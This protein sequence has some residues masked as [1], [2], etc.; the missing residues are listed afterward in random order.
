M[1]KNLYILATFILS[2]SVSSCYHEVDLDGYKDNDGKN[3]LTLN[4]LVCPDSTVAVSATRTYFFSDKHNERTYV[5]GLAI[6]LTI[7]GQEQETLSF[8]KSRNLYVSKSK[9]N[10]G[11]VVSISTDFDGKTIAGSDVVPTKTE[12]FDISVQRR[13][14]V[15]IY[16]NRDF[17][18]TYRLTFEDKPNEDNYYFLQWDEVDSRADVAMG[19]RDFTHELVFQKLADDVHETLPGWTP[20]CP[21]GLP[22]S[23]RGIDGQRHTIVVEEI[24]QGDEGSAQWRK[25]QMKRKFKLYSISKQYYNYLVSVLLNQTDDKG[26]N[27]GMIDLG[28]ADPVKVYSNITNGIGIF[29]CYSTAQ[30]EIDVFKEVGPFP[31][32]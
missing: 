6:K 7:N 12:I 21:Y 28:M 27:G 10:E 3:L 11:N 17:V 19:E 31:G 13:G 18:F 4:S 23:D 15:S 2:L 25:S 22:F 9:P 29:G 24:V 26:L 5:Q 1:N 8:D 32:K 16:T 20:Y 30:A 14:P